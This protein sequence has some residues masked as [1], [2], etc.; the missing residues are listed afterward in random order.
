MLRHDIIRL[1]IGVGFGAVI[2]FTCLTIG[3]RQN[4]YNDAI[5]HGTFTTDEYI[6]ELTSSVK[7]YYETQHIYPASLKDVADNITDNWGNPLIYKVKGE[8]FEIISYGADGKPGGTGANA[9]IS[10][11]DLIRKDY[12]PERMLQT[13]PDFFNEPSNKW[14][15]TIAFVAGILCTVT[16]YLRT[17]P[18]EFTNDII[19]RQCKAMAITLVAVSIVTWFMVV[20]YLPVHH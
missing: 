14:S 19:M 18:I 2:T 13:F 4:R 6:A 15:I 11:N 10:S 1:L 5:Y 20:L 12:F 17:K 7:N 8:E 3:I 9:D 16:Y